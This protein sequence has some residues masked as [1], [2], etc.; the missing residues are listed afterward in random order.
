MVRNVYLM[1][2][3]VHFLAKSAYFHLLQLCIIFRYEE[4][5]RLLNNFPSGETKPYL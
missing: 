3:N 2:G 1:V 5:I 4:Y